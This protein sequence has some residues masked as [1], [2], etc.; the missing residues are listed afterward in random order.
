M[1]IFLND[2]HMM[3]ALSKK[4]RD[5]STGWSPAN[6]KC[7]AAYGFY[8]HALSIE[9]HAR[10]AIPFSMRKTQGSLAALDSIPHGSSLQHRRAV[11]GKRPTVFRW[12]SA[13]R[14]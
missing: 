5:R 2:D 8:Q 10:K 3:A 14:A 4:R 12:N 6:D 9:I 11:N 7:I 1:A 13:A